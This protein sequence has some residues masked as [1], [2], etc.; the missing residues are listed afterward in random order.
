MYFHIVCGVGGP[1][2]TRCGW[3]FMGQMWGAEVFHQ[4]IALQRDDRCSLLQPSMFSVT[5]L[6]L[7]IFFWTVT[8][9][10]D[11][12]SHTVGEKNVTWTRTLI[13]S[14][15]CTWKKRGSFEDV[16]NKRCFIVVAF[17]PLTGGPW[18]TFVN[19]GSAVVWKVT[20]LWVSVSPALLRPWGGS[21][22]TEDLV[23]RWET[24]AER[25][26]DMKVRQGEEGIWG[27]SPSG[28]TRH[29]ST[30]PAA[31]TAERSFIRG[32]WKGRTRWCN[33]VAFMV[34]SATQSSLE[35]LLGRMKGLCDEIWHSGTGRGDIWNQSKWTNM[36]H[37]FCLFRMKLV[38]EFGQC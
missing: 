8:Q 28:T 34:D 14:S 3:V 37:L 27:Q 6:F 1:F 4:I 16:K 10:E 15:E 19:E 24:D 2:E 36:E 23:G 17:F 35:R 21:W 31:K 11:G 30:K 32:F 22:T 33:I 38:T 29:G 26:E 18:L 7:L 5:W 13:L 12:Y 9:L 20:S 25:G